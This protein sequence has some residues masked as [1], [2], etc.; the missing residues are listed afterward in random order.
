M[1][2]LY[3]SLHAGSPLGPAQITGALL[4]WTGGTVFAPFTFPF[5][6]ILD[7]TGKKAHYSAD[8]EIDNHSQYQ[9]RGEAGNTF[10]VPR[11]AN[12]EGQSNNYSF[13]SGNFA[14][15]VRHP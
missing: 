15:R 9:Y 11:C 3:K 2:R 10:R 4:P 7:L 13:G 8:I 5:K 14:S 1:P 6:L 12:T